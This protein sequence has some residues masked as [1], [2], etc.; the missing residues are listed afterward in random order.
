[1]KKV[2]YIFISKAAYSPLTIIKH[3]VHLFST[4]QISTQHC[5]VLLSTIALSPHL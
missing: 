1:M 3:L 2:I 5:V 4:F